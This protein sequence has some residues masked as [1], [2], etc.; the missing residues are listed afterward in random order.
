MTPSASFTARTPST[1][2]VWMFQSLGSLTMA[3]VFAGMEM[4]QLKEPSSLRH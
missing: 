1:L 4:V 3:D 2:G